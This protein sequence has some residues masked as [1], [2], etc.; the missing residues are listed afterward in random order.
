M[1]AEQQISVLANYIMAEVPNEP[2]CNEGAGDT[3]VRILR[4]YRSALERIMRE[5]GV[6]QQDYPAPVE[7]AY[8]IAEDT[9]GYGL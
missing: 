2:S 5:L 8:K 7:N 6:P 9:L 3:A 4:Q 1:S